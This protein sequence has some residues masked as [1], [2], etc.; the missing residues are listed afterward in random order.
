[1]ILT[2]SYQRFDNFLIKFS[3]RNNEHNLLRILLFI[4]QEHLVRSFNKGGQGLKYNNNDNKDSNKDNDNFNTLNK[5]IIC[6][7]I[8]KFFLLNQNCATYSL[9]SK[10][11]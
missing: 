10:L 1:M 9:K 7:K 8:K 6:Y 4:L 11:N 5:P 2:L 3:I